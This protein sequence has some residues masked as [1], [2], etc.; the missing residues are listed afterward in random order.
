MATFGE[1]LGEM[2]GWPLAP[3]HISKI[4]N[5]TA[6]KLVLEYVWDDINMCNEYQYDT[7]YKYGFII[8]RIC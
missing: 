5:Q 7:S 2:A 4:F 8:A 6:M 1:F 3:L